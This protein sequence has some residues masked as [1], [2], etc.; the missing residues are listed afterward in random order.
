[1]SAGHG[2]KELARYLT[3]P[4]YCNNWLRIGFTQADLSER[5]N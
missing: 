5:V 3:L 4:N 1:V 2:R